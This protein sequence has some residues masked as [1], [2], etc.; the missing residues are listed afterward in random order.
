MLIICCRMAGTDSTPAALYVSLNPQ[1][2]APVARFGTRVLIGAERHPGKGPD[3]RTITYFPDQVAA[4]P[5]EEYH[6]FRSEYDGALKAGDLVRRT[7]E[8]HRASLEAEQQR[9]QEKQE[10]KAKARSEARK[11]QEQASPTE[12]EPTPPKASK[13][14]GKRTE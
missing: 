11:A 6:R 14:K 12:P 8:D 10:A 2:P 9:E 7:A 5:L 1:R 13:A 3:R 4:I